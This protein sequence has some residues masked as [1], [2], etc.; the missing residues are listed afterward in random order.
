MDDFL[1]H[2]YKKIRSTRNFPISDADNASG[3]TW[4]VY[5]DLEIISVQSLQTGADADGI[6]TYVEYNYIY[7]IIF[8]HTMRYFLTANAAAIWIAT[9]GTTVLPDDPNAGT[10]SWGLKTQYDKNNRSR[11]DKTG[12]FEWQAIKVVTTHS[13]RY[14]WHYD[15][16]SG[17]A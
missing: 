1:T 5:G 9:V 17:G 3:I 11:F 16:P 13:L 8:T 4:P 12:D 14:T 7:Q 6:A 10:G 2:N 15:D